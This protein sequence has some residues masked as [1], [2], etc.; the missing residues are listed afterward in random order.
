MTITVK[1]CE[2]CND[3]IAVVCICA[4]CIRRH[5]LPRFRS[6]VSLKDGYQY[7]LGTATNGF[8]TLM[9]AANALF[10]ERSSE[11]V[12]LFAQMEIRYNGT[13]VY[14]EKFPSEFVVAE[15]TE[16]EPT[17]HERSTAAHAPSRPKVYQPYDQWG[18]RN[19]KPDGWDWD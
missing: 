11:D 16:P 18:N 2:M 13:A 8:D 17:E 6:Y 1:R 7:E 4:K 15:P 19:P 5:N 10:D 14:L 9:G 3:P 12:S